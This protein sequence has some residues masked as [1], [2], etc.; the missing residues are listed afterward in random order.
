M[1]EEN[2]GFG[3][4]YKSID[5]SQKTNISNTSSEPLGSAGNLES[6]GTMESGTMGSSYGTGG[7]SSKKPMADQSPDELKETIKEKVARGVAAVAG[8]LKGFSE[9]AKKQD[10]A[11]STKEAIQKAGETTRDV[12]STTKQEF[13]QTKETFKGGSQ[14]S[15]GG[16]QL[17]SS[18]YNKDSSSTSMGS[19]TGASD[20]DVT[21]VAYSRTTITT[22]TDEDEGRSS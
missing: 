2:T 13:Q 17:G 14:S 18:S 10:L 4:P 8:A 1:V 5:Q 11:G 22:L 6:S 19:T 15:S 16:S 9:E 7:S 21:G 12:A 20:A 3:S